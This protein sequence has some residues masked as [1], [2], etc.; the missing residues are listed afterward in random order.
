MSSEKA[1]K[2]LI[3]RLILAAVAVAVIAVLAAIEYFVSFDRLLPAYAL[4]PRE[5]GELRLHFL[6]VG[7][8]ACTIVE[9][10]EGDALVVDGGDG[11]FTNRNKLIRYLKGLHP[12]TVSLLLTHADADHY[13]GFPAALSA[14]DVSCCYLPETDTEKE[15]FSELLSAVEREGC[16]RKRLTRYD[17]I[18][19]GEASLVCLSPRLSEEADEDD[20][21]TVLYLDY[22]GVRA[23]L[24]GDISAQ[25]ERLLTEEYGLAEGIF[26]A[27]EHKVRLE[28]IEILGA[29]HHGSSNASSA[30][31]LSLLSP[32]A[33]IVSCGRDNGYGHP[34]GEALARFRA[35]SPD[36]EIYRTDELGDV[37]VS[38]QNGTYTISYRGIS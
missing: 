2:K 14:F 37:I 6:D 5:E 3:K 38:I 17:V 16:E 11:S 15:G 36:G 30:E 20:C 18:G 4:P 21:S 22:G 28:E 13:G 33:F 27:G 9:F 31:W 8:G 12:N 26:D 29:A 10:P 23:L 35:A 32:E 7:Q 19:E 34:S 1:K 24:C 25:R